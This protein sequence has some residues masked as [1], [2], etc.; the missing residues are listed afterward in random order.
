MK[1]FTTITAVFVIAFTLFS[2]TKELKANE[3]NESKKNIPVDE[4]QSYI[5]QS[6]LLTIHTGISINNVPQERLLS[7]IGWQVSLDGN[8]LTFFCNEFYEPDQDNRSSFDLVF[9]K[10]ET[11]NGRGWFYSGKDGWEQA[12]P[13]N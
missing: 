4:L 3:L 6:G 1:L 12:A 11:N 10:L 7:I 13:A 2:C 9:E 5:E 8:T